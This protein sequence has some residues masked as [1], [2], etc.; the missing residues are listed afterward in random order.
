[1]EGV[2]AD[3]ANLTFSISGEAVSI[4]RIQRLGPTTAAVLL[5][6][7]LNAAVS[8]VTGKITLLLLMQNERINTT[9]FIRIIG[10]V[11]L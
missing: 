6:T 3:G 2:S 1:L 9:K 7:T 5:T 11:W 4:L 8:K 10:E